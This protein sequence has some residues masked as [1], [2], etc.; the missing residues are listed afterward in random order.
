MKMLLAIAMAFMITLEVIAPTKKPNPFLPSL[1]P[2]V[3]R[4]YRLKAKY[5][6]NEKG[7]RRRIPI[8]FANLHGT[9][10]GL[11][12]YG[13]G[14]HYIEIDEKFWAE[15]SEANREELIFH[16]MGHCDLDRDHQEGE[17]YWN[18]TM[19]PKTIM[20]CCGFINDWDYW[21]D[22]DYYMKELFSN[23]CTVK[24]LK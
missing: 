8:R 3:E 12:Y 7:I 13:V 17:I 9:I 5:R 15:A 4:F 16:E 23:S 2:Y 1:Q 20:H 14:F 24:K 22:H 10:A 11:C 21:R 19:I 18:N 6:P